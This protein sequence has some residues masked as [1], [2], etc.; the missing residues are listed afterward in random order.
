MKNES[1]RVRVTEKLVEY[2]D[3]VDQKSKDN[4]DPIESYKNLNRTYIWH[5]SHLFTDELD[6]IQKPDYLLFIVRVIA[7]TLVL[8]FALPW[9]ITLFIV[10]T[11]VLWKVIRDRSKLKQR[12]FY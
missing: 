9:T 12:K 3:V 11:F 6:F 2:L 5:I 8:L 4:F 10:T 1:N 7:V